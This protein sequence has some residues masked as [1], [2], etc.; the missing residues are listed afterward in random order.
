MLSTRSLS[1]RHP[2]SDAT[3]A[4]PLSP[5]LYVVSSPI[6]NLQDMS[7]RAVDV[8][9]RCDRILCES[10]TRTRVLTSHFGVSTTLESFHD[11][12]EDAKLEKVL[13]WMEQGEAC[14]LISDAGTPTLNDPGQPLVAACAK[15]GI[16][17]VPIPGKRGGKGP[18]AITTALVASGLPT[19]AFRFCGFAPPKTAAR[20][21]AFSRLRDEEATLIFLIPPHALVPAL[22]DAAAQL[23]PERQCCVAREMTK[24]FEE[25]WWGTLRAAAEH[26][27]ARPVR[28]EVTLVV[29]GRARA[30]GGER[31][32]DDALRLALAD[33]LG[34]GLSRSAAA[35]R[36]AQEL[37]VRR[38]RVYALS[39]ELDS[40]SGK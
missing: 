27:A 4:A 5:G 20:Q 29:Q 2:E 40:A 37:D 19:H 28:G 26:W 10:P 12:N 8:L 18:S 34:A 23:G 38:K 17:L 36:V 16:L 9:R 30:E 3:P 22:L 14:A 7:P 25:F 1:A 32:S 31:V 6:G 24:V 39:L 13:T 35:A 11:H 15:R 33:H 21:S